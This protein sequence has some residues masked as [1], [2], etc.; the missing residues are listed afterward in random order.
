MLYT[1]QW[2]FPELLA[3][4]TCF[5]IGQDYRF[6]EKVEVPYPVRA[7]FGPATA[8]PKPAAPGE[9]SATTP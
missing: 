3:E 4:V 1:A 6:I 2:K 9:P 5:R 7:D 8:A